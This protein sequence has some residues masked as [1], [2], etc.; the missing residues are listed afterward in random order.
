MRQRHAYFKSNLKTRDEESGEKVIEGHFAVFNQETEL[1]EG[2][3]E[4]IAPGAFTKSIKNNDIRCLFNHNSGFV[5]GRNKSGTLELREDK[6]GLWGR[7]T[8]N[9]NDRQALDVYARVQR[10]DITGCSFGF[11]VPE[12]GETMEG[13]DGECHSTILE[14]DVDE[15]SICTFPA[16]P[17]TEIQA[18][19]K[20]AGET[21]KR[22]AAAEK[23]EL[24]Q[25]LEA[26][27]C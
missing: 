1:W 19:K 11:F 9:D 10:G 8:V 15:V 26:L 21:E 14:A 3:F 12:G 24:K 4:Q 5:L 23:A 25:R 13:E 27:K 7:V 17:Q 18:R 6:T 20:D 22:R 16:Y 2:W